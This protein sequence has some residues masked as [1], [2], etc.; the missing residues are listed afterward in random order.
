MAANEPDP[1]SKRSQVLSISKCICKPSF[2]KADNRNGF[3]TPLACKLQDITLINPIKQAINFNYSTAICITMLLVSLIARR[4]RAC[5]V[6]S[7]K[8]AV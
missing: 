5:T 1:T 7:R 4:L 3:C 8:T 6:L 2:L